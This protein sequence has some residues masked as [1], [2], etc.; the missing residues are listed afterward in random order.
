MTANIAP[1][2]IV[3]GPFWSDGDR[4]GVG[5][6]VERG[7]RLWTRVDEGYVPVMVING[8]RINGG[9]RP[10]SLIPTTYKAVPA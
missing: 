5:I 3:L 6:V 2:T 10:E 4:M 9:Y 1:G 7:H 8:D